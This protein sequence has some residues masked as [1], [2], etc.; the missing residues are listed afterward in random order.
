MTLTK[1]VKNK[2][3]AS[4][5]NIISP[6]K[7][8]TLF[9]SNTLTGALIRVQKQHA[10]IVKRILREGIN[11]LENNFL[12]SLLKLGFLVE[13]DTNELFRARM[14]HEIAGRKDNRLHLIVLTT[15]QCNFRC[16]YCYEKFEKGQ[17]KPEVI[18]GMKNYVN[19]NIKYLDVLELQWFGGEP[20]LAINSID[21]LS[22]HFISLCDKYEVN[23]SAGIT[24]NGYLLNNKNID[25]LLKNKVTNFQITLDGD[26]ETHDCS[27]TLAGGQ[28]T[29][30]KIYNNLLN[31][32]DKDANFNCRIR[33]NFDKNNL[34][35]LPAFIDKLKANFSSDSRFELDFFPVG[36]WGGPNDNKL[37]ILSKKESSKA[38]LSLCHTATE[39]GF[40]VVKDDL[41]K[42]GGYVC[43][44][45]NPN[46]YVIG[47]DGIIY[48][49]TVALYSDYNQIGKLNIDGT[50]QV[51]I[52]KYALWV[53][54]DESEDEGCKKCFL[55]P[56]CQGASCPL[57]R[58]E[59]GK[60]PCPPDKANIKEV[61]RVVGRNRFLVNQN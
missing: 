57:I 41:L 24:T 61:V 12:K 22:T 6:D 5:Y 30:A 21:E 31:L 1:S 13:N 28:K 17:L 27:R 32:K 7:D 52:D 2:Y 54:N 50:M 44:A 56:S 10:P 48:K 42:P 15:E 8:G 14:L 36:K 23:Y 40:R 53:M 43:Y 39:Q 9:L 4:R 38:A 59:T 37:D 35:A 16:S 33:I 55:R 3:V 45:A 46:S 29:F 11:N 34:K 25:I 18:E 19:N 47:S 58:I 49:C 26:E 51:D 20:L 60:A